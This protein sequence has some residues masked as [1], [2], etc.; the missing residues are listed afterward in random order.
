MSKLIFE[1]ENQFVNKVRKYKILLNN[2]DTAEIKN[3]ERKEIDVAPGS[4]KVKIMVDWSESK[5]V[6]V[7]VTEGET[8]QFQCGS[9]LKGLKVFQATK[10][11]DKKDEFVYLDQIK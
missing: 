5:E 2:E 3:G 1:R 6:L 9:R 11:M 4:Y 7:N 10:A 8:L